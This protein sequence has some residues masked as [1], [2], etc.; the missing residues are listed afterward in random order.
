MWADAIVDGIQQHEARTGAQ[1]TLQFP[2]PLPEHAERLMDTLGVRATV[3]PDQLAATA[4][5]W[6]CR[7]GYDTDPAVVRAGLQ[8]LRRY[9]ADVAVLEGIVRRFGLA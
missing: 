3:S 8:G 7:V 9:Y 5:R 2:A 1:L 6:I 4:R